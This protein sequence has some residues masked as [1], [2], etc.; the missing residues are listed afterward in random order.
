MIR[1]ILIV[2]TMAV[3][4]AAGA[5]PFH[6]AGTFNGW[7]PNGPALA[8]TS[9]GSGIWQVTLNGLGAGARHEAKVT[10]GTW[11]WSFPGSGNIWFYADGAGDL[12]LSY[13]TNTYGD[14]WL[15]S[16]Q[17]IGVS[18]WMS[19]WTAVGDWQGWN[20]A[21]AASVMTDMGGGI[22]KYTATG[23]ANGTY[24][25]KAVNT[26]TWDAIGGDARSVNAD[27]IPFTIDAANPVAELLVN[28]PQGTIRANAVPEPASLAALALGAAALIRRRRAA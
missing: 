2:A 1:S 28:V 24:Q 8:E 21:N 6:V 12:T 10:D 7:D 26:G 3:L 4:G 19:S 18:N 25:Y 11:G 20:N 5:Q 23:L 22:F 13:D 9:S 27:A 14:G 15:N 16:T 17:R